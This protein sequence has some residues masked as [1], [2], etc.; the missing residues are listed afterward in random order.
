GNGEIVSAYWCAQVAS[1]VALTEKMRLGARRFPTWGFHR[2]TDAAVQVSPDIAAELHR[3]DE[4]AVRANTIL[5]GVRQRICM[6]LIVAS[7]AHLLALVDASV[8]GADKATTA[9]A[10]EQ[11]KAV[12]A[13]AEAYYHEAANGQAQM[14]Y[15]G[16]MAAV[17][18][19]LSII[20]AVWLSIT[21]ASPVAALAAGAAGAVVSVIQRINTGRFTL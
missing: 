15:F 2:Q 5:S 16:G 7:A 19:V 13:K 20:S 12:I 3:C 10:L 14:V 11:E 9:A 18:I 8:R 21:W 4:L 17:A 1:A 6:Q